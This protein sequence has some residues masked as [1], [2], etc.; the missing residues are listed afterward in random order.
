MKLLLYCIIAALITVHCDYCDFCVANDAK[1]HIYLDNPVDVF[2]KVWYCR[3]DFKEI[4]CMR[5]LAHPKHTY[6]QA[7]TITVHENE[8]CIDYIRNLWFALYGSVVQGTL[9]HAPLGFRPHE[10]LM[11]SMTCYHRYWLS[12]AKCCFLLLS[13]R[14]HRLLTTVRQ[15]CSLRY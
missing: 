6:K 13:C 5:D 3:T 14:S 12:W 11:I 2:C 4:A 10:F 9:L 8:P 15:T 7:N 1:Q